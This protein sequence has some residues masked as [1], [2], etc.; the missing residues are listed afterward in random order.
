MFGVFFGLIL[1]FISFFCVS[2]CL[3]FGK[4]SLVSLS[5]AFSLSLFLSFSL[6]LDL[7]HA[8]SMYLSR[9]T[10]LCGTSLQVSFGLY[11]FLSISFSL[12]LFLSISLSLF[13][14]DN[15]LTRIT[16][17]QTISLSISLSF[18][19]PLTHSIS[20]YRRPSFP[21]ELTLS[22]SL[23]EQTNTTTN[24]TFKNFIPQWSQ[25]SGKAAK[26]RFVVL[27]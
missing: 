14:C 7:A 4:R 5:I 2:I 19:L 8:H 24:I 23:D 1:Q 20:H 9:S 15:Q 6:C 10:Y 17:A 27:F 22:P 26:L 16:L 11:L 25:Q 3:C 13:F 18:Y 21:L 12:D